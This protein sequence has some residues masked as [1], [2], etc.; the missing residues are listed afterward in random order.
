MLGELLTAR[1]AARQAQVEGDAEPQDSENK[2]VSL[3]PVEAAKVPDS[4]RTIEASPVKKCPATELR[5][6]VLAGSSVYIQENA[7]S[8]IRQVSKAKQAEY[9]KN[10]NVP[11]K[12]FGGLFKSL[13]KQFKGSL[14]N[15]PDKKLKKLTLPIMVPT[16]LDLPNMPDENGCQLV[17]VA[18]GHWN[19]IL[20]CSA[21][22][23]EA[24]TMVKFKKAKNGDIVGTGFSEDNMEF[25]LL[26][27]VTVLRREGFLTMV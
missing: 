8:M 22:G 11:L 5:E 9:L 13:S 15:I 1:K 23:Q 27:V 7:I 18:N 14:A 21:V 4:K 3:P 19:G 17:F 16:G 6:I 20:V 10:S 25:P 12:D 26:N 24:V 2:S